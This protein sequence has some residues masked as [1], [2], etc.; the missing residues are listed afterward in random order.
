M[1]FLFWSILGFL[2]LLF[3]FYA[4][5]TGH[6]SLPRKILIL[7]V[8][9]F[10]IKTVTL[11]IFFSEDGVYF[12]AFGKRGRPLIF[13]DK[14]TSVPFDIRALHFTSIKVR[15]YAGG[16]TDAT[17]YLLASLA[18]IFDVGMRYL[19]EERVLDAGEVLILPCYVNKQS[20]VN[21]SMRFFTSIAM[22]FACFFH[23]KKGEKY[24]K[25]S[26]RRYHG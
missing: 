11:K 26:Y 10:G 19:R 16:E 12:S 8:R 22:F 18:E 13:K 14:K 24:A 9:L 20:S 21:L 4:E 3:P 5:I 7:S 1:S 25:R 6:F 17:T 15:I 23:T 2:I